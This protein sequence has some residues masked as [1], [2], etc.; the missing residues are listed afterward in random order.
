MN[1]E[2]TV[3][4][5]GKYS[6]K[7]FKYVLKKDNEYCE[8]FLRNLDYDVATCERKQ[9]YNYLISLVKNKK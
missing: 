4:K 2:K 1:I 6:G 5:F 9:F 3:L 7:T 8:W